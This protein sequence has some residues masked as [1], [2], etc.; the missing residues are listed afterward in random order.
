LRDRIDVG[1]VV[2]NEEVYL[3]P[4]DDVAQD[5]R[6]VGMGGGGD[7]VVSISRRLFHDKPI[8]MTPGDNERGVSSLQASD[9]IIT[10]PGTGTGDEDS[11]HHFLLRAMRFRSGVILPG[12]NPEISVQAKG[13]P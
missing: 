10:L 2:W 8:G 5:I 9:E 3:L 6:K 12:G 4:I 7:E 13:M 11:S 1:V